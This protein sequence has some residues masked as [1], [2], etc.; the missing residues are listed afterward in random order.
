M[1]ILT[2]A[3]KTPI[4]V[5]WQKTL[6]PLLSELQREHGRSW[7]WTKGGCFAFADAF[8]N[9]FGGEFAVLILRVLITQLS[10]R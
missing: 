3:A 9:V 2:L 1:K 8:R 7:S 4:P 5:K 10:T 6:S